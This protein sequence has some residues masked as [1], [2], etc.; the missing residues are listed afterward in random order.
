MPIFTIELQGRGIQKS[1][2]WADTRNGVMEFHILREIREAFGLDRALFS[3]RGNVIFADF[4]SVREFAK[5]LNEK[6]NPLVRPERYIQA[7]KLNAMG[8][9]DEILHY[10][11]ALYREQIAP[12][13]YTKALETLE[14]RFGKAQVDKF[15]IEFV[16][17]FPPQEVY[18]GSLSPEAYLKSTEGG[19][20]SRELALEEFL[21]LALANANPAFEP[22]KFLF[23]DTKLQNQKIY[24]EFLEAFQAY[25]A[26]LPGFGPDDQTL[27]EL[28]RS[29]AVAQPHSLTG[30]LE[31]IRSR[32]GLLIGKYLIR[33]LTSLDVVK[34]EEKPIFFGP[35]PTRAYIYNELEREYER[36]SEDRD[37]MPRT[38]LMAKSTL[39]WLHQLSTK[40]GRQI[41]RLDQI[42]EEELDILASCGFT[43]LWLIGLW[44]RSKA[45]REIKQ[46]CGNPEAAASAYSLHDYDIAETLGGWQALDTLRS[47]CAWRGIRLG[48]DMVPNHTG[49][50]S[51]W[52]MDHPDRFLQLDHS[53]F[54]TY[55]FNGK[56]LSH[57]EGVGIFLEDHYYDKTDAAVVFKRTDYNTGQDRYI[58]HGND[59]TSMPWND[60]AQIDFL[61]PE[62]REAVIATI[63]GVCK[64]FPIVR[65]D[66]A[67]TL[68]KKHIQRLWF[69]E[70][71]HGGDIPSRAEH[72]LSREDFNRLI[73]Q[74]FW[75]EVVD[76]CAQEAP[77]TLLLAEAFWMMEGYF[78]RTLGM[79]RVYNSAFMNMLKEEEN[80]KYR[81]TIKNTLEFD[82]QILQRFVNFMN[83][84]DEETAVAQ[85]GKGDKYFGI[86]TLMATM[87]GLPMFGHGQI[88]GFEEKYGMEYTK[89]YRDE[90][91]DSDLVARHEREIFPLL[92][93]RRLFAGSADFALYD[94]F[95]S[96]AS[97]NENVF[98]YSNRL[99]DERALVLY[100]NSY[101]RAAGWIRVASPIKTKEGDNSHR[102]L[103]RTL[104]EAL[105]LQGGKD[106][107]VVFREQRSDHWFIRPGAEI[108]NQGLFIALE[109]Y[110]SQV[111]LDLHEV[112][113]S[114]HGRWKR[115]CH[116]LGG[117]GVADLN[118]AFQDLF[119]RDLYLA[120]LELAKPSY[121]NAFQA[122]FSQVT[123][124]GRV[125]ARPPKAAPFIAT[126]REPT[127]RFI[128]LARD[129]LDGASGRYESFERSKEYLALGTEKVW[130]A[131][132]LTVQRLIKLG[133]YAAKTP[134]T[135]R[136]GKTFIMELVTRLSQ[137][138][139]VAAYLAGY[140]VLS[141]VRGIIGEG[142]GGKEGRRLINHWCL[143]RKLRESY[144][145]AGFPVEE[146]YR[147]VELL[148]LVLSRTASQGHYESD[149]LALSIAQSSLQEEDT[150]AFLG[151]NVFNDVTWFNKERFEE[152]LFYASAILAI[153]GDEAIAGP[154]KQVEEKEKD[155]SL[156]VP[157]PSRIN[158]LHWNR[159]IESIARVREDLD[160]AAK[161]SGYRVDDF[162]AA[163]GLHRG[164][165]EKP[166]RRVEKE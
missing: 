37:W 45:S 128:G 74:E 118:A 158:T 148:K 120:F 111:F 152:I 32:W 126:L 82:P 115:L 69:P 104:T 56:N 94:L 112:Q 143:D 75:R 96:D 71:G 50:D 76:R 134:A 153:E 161:L 123:E 142:A 64:Q 8:L 154:I 140:V 41:T 65:F 136:Y 137:E 80:A 79:H 30:Q 166:S 35:G 109:G 39:V 138:P 54:P 13:A 53:P 23:D 117:R 16:R 83:N 31:Y 29:P 135:L 99:G 20:K 66:A 130:I 77:D 3:L 38:V 19:E 159:R 102:I 162:L 73:P 139:R 127:L 155:F 108:N 121:F 44:E 28:L 72:G 149:S 116:E 25:L 150:A 147:V 63:L 43:G 42:P 81:S 157:H 59:G 24:P 36:F 21:L 164:K 156:P 49:I 34:E 100:N 133:E 91:P 78:V 67:M 27:W 132:A 10:I 88:E 46:S 101:Q 9:I 60:T 6:E 11:A 51:R 26:T 62:A 124:E 163:L 131:F 57:R 14:T 106:H 160:R 55:S 68:A 125:K 129:Y 22:F 89:A 141:L 5:R 58:Y 92:K 122:F 47:R 105:A 7:G 145:E 61:N 52:I 144:S 70:P 12:D 113:D 98:V 93:K 114:V 18:E 2:G 165:K 33:L 107:Y 146:S 90:R 119:L 40:Y 86:C 48:S 17:L 103:R 4:H 95:N 97:V 15:L 151:V 84:P 87:P 110:Q 85:F 1:T